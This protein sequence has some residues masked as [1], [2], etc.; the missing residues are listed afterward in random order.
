MDG[1]RTGLRRR[2]ERTLR[3]VRQQHAQL[4]DVDG[5]LGKA[6]AA[7]AWS[8]ARDWLERMRD[9]FR[10]HFDLEEEVIFPAV[11]GLLPGTLKEI[12][13]LERDHQ[14]FLELLHT[15]LGAQPHA[16]LSRDVEALRER[17]DVHERHE[18]RLLSLALALEDEPSDEV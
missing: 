3:T 13:R 6:L 11:H 14:A 10:A 9:A 5:E 15:A 8:E 4:R 17:L 7:G 1:M 18:E 12:A 16:N 2:L